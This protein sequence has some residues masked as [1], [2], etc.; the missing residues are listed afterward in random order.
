MGISQLTEL[1][2]LV[3]VAAAILL[4]VRLIAHLSRGSKQRREER[5]QEAERAAEERVAGERA[6]ANQAAA[7]EM[8]ARRAAIESE[9]AARRAAME[10]TA[11]QEAAMEKAALEQAIAEWA[12][13]EQAE[14]ERAQLRRSREGRWDAEQ[15]E[16][17]MEAVEAA[18]ADWLHA[19]QES[20]G[21]DVIA[22]PDK[23]EGKKYTRTEA[24]RQQVFLTAEKV[25]KEVADLDF[26]KN[27]IQAG[28]DFL[29][30][31][32]RQTIDDWK[33]GATLRNSTFDDLKL[34][35]RYKAYSIEDGYELLYLYNDWLAQQRQ[36]LRV[37]IR[38]LGTEV[39][40]MESIQAAIER[41]EI[42]ERE[43]YLEMDV[44]IIFTLREIRSILENLMRME[45]ILRE[46]EIVCQKRSEQ[47]IA[48][49]WEAKGSL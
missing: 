23:T 1:F 28:V 15:L 8:A 47:I 32:F 39:D 13:A 44:D 31:E 40:P 48:P 26:I 19:E 16:E 7:N 20:S 11:A 3:G 5:L 46:L 45:A 38:L 4:A 21:L 43:K 10:A 37:F 22:V 35:F 36:K 2:V 6:A 33:K 42:H 14:G 24:I 27:R 49:P 18:I 41:A 17:R 30:I 25:T 9:V 12:A 29:P 34:K